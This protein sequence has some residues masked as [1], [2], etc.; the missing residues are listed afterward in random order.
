VLRQNRCLWRGFAS[1]CFGPSAINH[2]E[3][4]LWDQYRRPLYA[5]AAQL[6]VKLKDSTMQQ[7]NEDIRAVIFQEGDQ[8][9]AQCLEY[10]IGAQAHDLETVQHRLGVALEIERQT[11]M[12]IYG[13]EF[14]GIDRAPARYFEMWEKRSPSS[15]P[16]MMKKRREPFALDLALCG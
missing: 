1:G 5:G 2:F 16:R 4:Q 6:A 3:N 12:E 13:T 11:S 14:D 10:D 9:V 8:W 7:K 15:W